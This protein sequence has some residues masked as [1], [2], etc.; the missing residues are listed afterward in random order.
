MAPCLCPTDTLSHRAGPRGGGS[1]HQ[2]R[3]LQLLSPPPPP[4]YTHTYTEN[5]E[6]AR[7]RSHTLRHTIPYTHSHSDTQT[8]TD[9]PPCSARLI[10]EKAKPQPPEKVLT[11]NKDNRNLVFRD[12]DPLCVCVWK[13]V[14]VKTETPL[15]VQQLQSRQC[16]LTVGVERELYTFNLDFPAFF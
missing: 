12:P 13:G 11:T 1:G 9:G 2:Y 6:T 3:A 8:H 15:H 4:Q 7:S 10:P 16:G 5:T 14:C